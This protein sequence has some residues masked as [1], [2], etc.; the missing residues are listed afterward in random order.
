MHWLASVSINVKLVCFTKSTHW[1]K[2]KFAVDKWQFCYLHVDKWYFDINVQKHVTNL[3]PWSETA[4]ILSVDITK[5]KWFLYRNSKWYRNPTLLAISS[6]NNSLNQ[7]KAVSLSL[8][9]LS[10]MDWN[11]CSFSEDLNIV[12]IPHFSWA[13]LHKSSPKQIPAMLKGYCHTA[14]SIRFNFP[15]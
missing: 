5:L 6:P 11:F 1:M 13:S 12:F 10:K 14:K 9:V 15:T 2:T 8:N 4:W 7:S 3:S